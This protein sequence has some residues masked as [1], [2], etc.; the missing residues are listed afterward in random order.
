MTALEELLQKDCD[1]EP[2]QFIDAKLV[3]DWL[4]DN[5]PDADLRKWHMAN[6]HERLD[7]YLFEC[8][9][10]KSKQK[11]LKDYSISELEQE[12]KRRKAMEE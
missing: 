1:F 9:M 6:I 12:I 2:W 8:A 10:S 11:R 4:W 5:V 3:L 7:F